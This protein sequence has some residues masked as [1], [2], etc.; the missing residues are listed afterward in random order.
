MK[1]I[2]AVLMLTG[3]FSTVA[4]AQTAAP[5]SKEAKPE[6]SKEEK[7]KQKMKQDEDMAAAFKEV[8]LSEDQI[9]QIKEVNAVSGKKSSEIKKD[10]SL[11]DEAKKEKSKEVTAEKNKKLKEIMGE[12]KFKQYNDIRKKQKEAAQ[13]KM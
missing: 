2:I 3:L 13:S 11:S 12:E 5:A 9:K 6:I 10:D 7:A 8:G 1:K 4:N